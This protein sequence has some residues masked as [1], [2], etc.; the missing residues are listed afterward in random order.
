MRRN[1]SDLILTR[2]VLTLF[3]KEKSI[4]QATNAIDGFT[5][6]NALTFK[7]W[8]DSEQEELGQAGFQ[9]AAVDPHAGAFI[10][11]LAF[12][13]TAQEPNIPTEFG[14]NAVY[15]NPFNS[16]TKIEYGLIEDTY[17][18]LKVFDATGRLVKT[19][20]QG[21][22]RK[23]QYSIAFDSIGLSAGSY[24]LKMQADRNSSV[25]TLQIV[26]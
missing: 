14:L 26:K 25:Q 21:A 2:F 11:D 16:T 22:G 1:P 15:P 13:T 20:A 23:G 10:T 9:T 19:L 8:D 5:N 6:A 4:N 12:E 24:I 7:Y 3:V 18:S 17:Y